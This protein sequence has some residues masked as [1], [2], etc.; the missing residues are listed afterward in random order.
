MMELEKTAC[1]D[2]DVWVDKYVIMPNHIHV[3]FA[4]GCFKPGAGNPTLATVVGLY[5]SAVSKQIHECY[6]RLSVWKKAA[7]MRL[8]ETSPTIFLCG[9]TLTG[10]RSNGL[11][12]SIIFQ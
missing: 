4:I 11:R 1:H 7:M 8:F 10:I 5:K 12:M 3:I 9:T 6:P 2:E